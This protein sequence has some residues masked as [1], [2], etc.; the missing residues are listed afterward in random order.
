MSEAKPLSLSE[1]VIADAELPIQAADRQRILIGYGMAAAGAILFSLKAI[2]VKLAYELDVDPE[3][4]LALRMGFSL[5][6]YLGVGFLAIRPRQHKLAAIPSLRLTVRAMLVG[7]LGMWVASYADFLG[8][9]YISAQFERLI[10]LT[11]PMFVVLFGAMFFGE[12]VRPRALI[13]LGVSYAGLGLIF[14]SENVS[15]QGSNVTLGAGLVLIGAIAFA[16]YQLL[17]KRA[18]DAIGP[19]LFTCI[20]MTGASLAAFAE[21]FTHHQASQL[22]VTGT[23]LFYAVLVAIASTVLPTFLMS[24][25]LYRISAQS[26]ATIGILSPVSTIL[27][28]A[29]I[30]GERL[31]AAG[32]AGMAL[33]FLGVGWFTFAERK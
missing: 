33:V 2:I 8:L 25:A 30:L 1:E 32:I 15:A 29:L 26:N 4:L 17:A 31:T 19:K 20:G 22:F 7:A 13:A 12:R 27:L 24:A 5:P 18:I 6:F 11:Y 23:L 21:F 9:Q 16:M 28:A 3:T 14:L 10:L